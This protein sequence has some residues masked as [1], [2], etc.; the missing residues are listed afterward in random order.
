M[1]VSIYPEKDSVEMCFEGATIKLFIVGNEVHIAE[2]VTYEVTTGEVL[3]KLQVVIKDGK[4]YLQSPFG[5]NEI[6]SPE[7]IFK[8][9]KAVLEEIKEKHKGLYEKFNNLV[10]T[11][12]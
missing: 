4:A 11:T 3:S 8:G 10:P 7:N 12:Q 6:S 1:K 9:I 2:E 5:L